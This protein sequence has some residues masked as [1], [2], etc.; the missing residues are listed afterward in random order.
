[1]VVLLRDCYSGGGV[2]V[3]D[4]GYKDNNTDSMGK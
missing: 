1:M 3:V 2:D 4:V